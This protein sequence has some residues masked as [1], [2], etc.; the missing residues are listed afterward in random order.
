MELRTDRLGLLLDQLR[1]SCE[2]SRARLAGLTDDEY[3]WEPVAGAWSIRRR[4]EARTPQA[5]GAADWVIDWADLEPKP[6]PVTTIAWRLNHLYAGFSQRWDWTFGDRCLEPNQ[7]AI[8]ASAAETLDRFWT[9][10]NRWS[11]S[12][13]AMTDEQLDTVGFGQYPGGLDPQLPFVCIVWWTN[14]EFIHHMGEIGLLRDL[15]AAR[16]I[17]R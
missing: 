4:A 11:A 17:V 15:W 6:A 9:L 13:G 16:N 8:S 10:M 7:I 5:F 14:R 12:V 2:I 3:R 1:T